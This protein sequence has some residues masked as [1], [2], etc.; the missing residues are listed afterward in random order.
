MDKFNSLIYYSSDKEC[1][2]YLLKENLQLVIVI[3]LKIINE[4]N[5]NFSNSKIKLSSWLSYT[6]N[7]YSEVMALN[8][9]KTILKFID[10]RIEEKYFTD[11][12]SNINKLL[13]SDNN[14]DIFNY[15][16]LILLLVISIGFEYLKYDSKKLA[17]IIVY[18]SYKKN[19]KKFSDKY[20]DFNFNKIHLNNIS[21]EVTEFINNKI[22]GKLQFNKL[23]K[24]SLNTLIKIYNEY[25]GI[26]YHSFS[27]IY[28]PIIP[29]LRNSK[30]RKYD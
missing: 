3:C 21:S 1:K 22:F 23:I 13:D 19:N 25:N 24:N 10:N 12:I 17:M 2:K 5:C 16:F 11:I 26:D 18:I 6:D 14:S 9:E 8:C 30:R 29:L 27:D 7:T 28:L 20:E 15:T 4:R